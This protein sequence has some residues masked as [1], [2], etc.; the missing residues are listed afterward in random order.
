MRDLTALIL[1]WNEQ[2]NIER[3]LS[4]LSW[5]PRVLIIDSLSTDDTCAI[6]ARHPNVTF[7]ER[8]FDTHTQ[9]WN[10]GLDHVETAWVLSLDAD[11][12]VSPEL[13]KEIQAVEP[14]DDV[15]AY[16]AAF[17]YL[18]FGRPLRT[19]IYPPR[20]VLFR[21][22]RARYQDDGHTQLLHVEGAVS[23]LEGK[24]DHDDRKPLSRWI[25]SQ[26]RYMVIEARH[27]LSTPADRLKRQDRLRKRIYFAPTVM[28]LYLLFGRG[29]ILDGWPGWYYVSQRTA[30]ELLLSLRLLTERQGLEKA[31]PTRVSP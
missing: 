9:Q 16:A 20:T 17:R 27:L 10:F 19:S 25:A 6:A 5:V 7:L 29:L 11:Y 22:D 30:A 2:E 31:D 18:I 14:P 28:F 4:A 26:D 13:A 15:T 1:T 21:K 12:L 3:S 24:I 23:N 8:A